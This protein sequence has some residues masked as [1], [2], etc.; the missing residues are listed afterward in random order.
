MAEHSDLIVNVLRCMLYLIQQSAKIL[1][2]IN[3]EKNRKRIYFLQT[4][5][6]NIVYALKTH[7]SIH[8]SQLKHRI[9][10]N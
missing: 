1:S 5:Q 2:Q 9:P 6:L 3:L 10:R 4:T 7:N 8:K